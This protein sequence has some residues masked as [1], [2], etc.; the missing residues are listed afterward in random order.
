MGVLNF[1]FAWLR[2]PF[3]AH[4][5]VL[6]GQTADVV[7]E[8]RLRKSSTIEDE[9][10]TE[11]ERQ[12]RRTM[13]Y[14]C[15]RRC[16][17]WSQA[18]ESFRTRVVDQLQAQSRGDDSTRCSR[19]IQQKRRCLRASCPCC[20]STKPLKLLHLCC[21]WLRPVPIEPLQLSPTRTK[22]T[23]KL[24]KHSQT[25]DQLWH[26]YDPKGEG[27]ITIEQL[28]LIMEEMNSPDPVEDVTV[29]FVLRTVD[30]SCTGGK[31]THY[32]QRVVKHSCDIRCERQEKV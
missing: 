13:R 3:E 17:G 26:K 30:Q 18:P 19:S 11:A 29:D 2:A 12:W 23:D 10:N 25:L 16:C 15:C 27:S 1:G 7:R 8:A 22:L 6:E 5:M 31:P 32:C 28:R 24:R 14:R 20:R 21:Y 4:L 9:H